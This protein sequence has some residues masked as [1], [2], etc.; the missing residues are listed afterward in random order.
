MILRFIFIGSFLTLFNFIIFYFLTKIFE[1]TFVLLL[2]Y[3]CIAIGLKFFI[4]KFFVFNENTKISLK[5]QIS[6][7]YLLYLF[8]FITNYIILELFK[9]YTEYNLVLC[10]IIF[11]IF[12]APLSYLIMK[13]RIFSKQA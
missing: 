6:E 1:A 9:K 7:Y 13:R 3:W 11:I 2:I 8:G 4:Y 12:F 10:Q 5:K